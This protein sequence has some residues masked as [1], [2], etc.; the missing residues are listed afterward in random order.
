MN[1]RPKIIVLKWSVLICSCTVENVFVTGFLGI[2]G[3]TVVFF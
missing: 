2:A 3:Q 1:R